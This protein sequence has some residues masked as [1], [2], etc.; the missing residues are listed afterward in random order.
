M[1][2]EVFVA[3]IAQEQRPAD[4]AY[5]N[6]RHTG[7]PVSVWSPVE[8]REHAPVIVGLRSF[9]FCLH[10][11]LTVW[12]VDIFFRAFQLFQWP[13]PSLYGLVNWLYGFR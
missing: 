9:Y 13:D 4:Q 7:I 6:A 10:H 11:T 8:T 2:I 3:F 5:Q 1:V 12:A